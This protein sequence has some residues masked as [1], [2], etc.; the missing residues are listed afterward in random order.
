VTWKLHRRAGLQIPAQ[1]ERASVG[2]EVTPTLGFGPIKVA[3][4]C[5]V[6]AVVQDEYRIGFAYGTLPGH[7]ESGEEAFVVE[8]DPSGTDSEIRLRVVAFSRHARWWS[9]LGGPVSRRMQDVMTDRYLR[10]LSSSP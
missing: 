4:P 2:L 8:C 9:K 6:V 10:A 1:T 3:A 5:R 7:P